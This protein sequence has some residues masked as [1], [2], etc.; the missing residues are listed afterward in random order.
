MN[1]HSHHVP[2]GEPFDD[3]LL[4]QPE[5]PELTVLVAMRT[6]LRPRCDGRRAQQ[7]WQEILHVA[8]LRGE[9]VERFD[10]VMCSLIAVSVR[11][12]D[13]R[14]RCAT[15]LAGDEAVLLQT[16][17]LLQATRSDAAVRLLGE[18]LPQPAVSGIVK[19]IRWLAIDLLEAGLEIRV[20]ER[21]ATYMH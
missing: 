19:L 16:I 8:G 17:A 5:G 6:W 9:G 14:C 4:E 7:H 20:R 18:W 15:G 3:R 13:L 11:P 10:F 12:L 21:H 2:L 1:P